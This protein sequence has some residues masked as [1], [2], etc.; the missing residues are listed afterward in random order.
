MKYG[1]ALLVMLLTGPSEAAETRVLYDLR[2]LGVKLGELELRASEGP[3]GYTTQ[4]S[5]AT[6]GAIGLIAK[7]RFDM[8][9]SG[10]VV[11]GTLIPVHY[12]EDVN[13]GRR[14]STETV[15]FAPGDRRLDPMSALYLGLRDRPDRQGCAMDRELFDGERSM[16]IVLAETGRSEGRVICAGSLARGAGYSAEDLA[17]RSEFPMTITYGIVDGVLRVLEARINS[18]HGRVVLLRR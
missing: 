12:S 4:A 2:M 6:K 7:V 5:F 15:T 1:L 10:R 11:G 14:H 8:L 17:E 16:H 13:T 3:A 9:A 18:L